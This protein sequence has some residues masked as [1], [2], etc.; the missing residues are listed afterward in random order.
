MQLQEGIV[1]T[2]R[3]DQIM[4]EFNNGEDHV[5]RVQNPVVSRLVIRNQDGLWEAHTRGKRP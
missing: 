2:E 4:P 1:I 5:Q 3:I